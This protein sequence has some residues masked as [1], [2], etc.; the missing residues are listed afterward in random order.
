MRM[1]DFTKKIYIR[2]RIA[3]LDEPAPEEMKALLENDEVNTLGTILFSY[4]SFERKGE[5]EYQPCDV[6]G[7]IGDENGMPIKIASN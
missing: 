5:L 3:T 4:K 6:Y 1:L 2:G 7:E